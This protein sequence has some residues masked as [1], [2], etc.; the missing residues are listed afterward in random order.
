MFEMQRRSFTVTPT[1]SGHLLKRRRLQFSVRLE[2]ELACQG[3]GKWCWGIRVAGKGSAIS[4]FLKTSQ[5]ICL[6]SASICSFPALR[7]REHCPVRQIPSSIPQRELVLRKV[8]ERIDMLAE[9]S[10]A[11]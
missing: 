3:S 7:E 11:Q 10:A 5:P 1:Q 2:D 8:A 9:A 4:F 6:Q